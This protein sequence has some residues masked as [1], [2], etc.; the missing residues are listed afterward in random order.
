M[1][2]ATVKLES[3]SPYQQSR[4]YEV[5]KLPKE[6]PKDYEER[7]W[8]NRMHIDENGEV[9]IPPTALKNCLSECARFLGRQIP[10]KGKS[11]YTKHFEAGVLIAE[12]VKLG[13]KADSVEGLWL[14]VPS[15]G[16]RGGSSRVFKCFPVIRKWSGVAVFHILDETITQDVFREHLEEAGRFIGIGAFRPRNNGYFGRFVVKSVDWQ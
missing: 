3:V 5:T 12:P 10:G 2:T 14:F 15:D 7:T 6:L 11:T 16:K 8:R 4:H 13:V 9:F 1:K